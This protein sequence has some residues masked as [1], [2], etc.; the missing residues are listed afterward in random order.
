[1][2]RDYQISAIEEIRSHFDRKTKRVLLHLLTGAG[3]T[4]T[5]CEMLN[6]A[7]KKGTPSLLVVHMNQ[8]IRQAEERLIEDGIP[9]GVI[10]GNRT[11]DEFELIRVCS[12]QTL[13]RRKLI[14]PAKFIVIDE[15]H[16]TD[17]DQYKWLLDQYPD[18]Y[19]L[20]VT[21]TPHLKN[22]MRHV[23]DVVVKTITP[24]GL[25]NRGFV[26]PARYFATA[27]K[28]DLSDVKIVR[29]DYHQ[30]QLGEKMSALVGDVVENYR[31]FADGLPALAFA[32]NVKHS[33][34]IAETFNR[35][36]IS[37][38]H[39][40]A[41]TPYDERMQ[42]VKKLTDGEIKII[43][44][45]GTL[46]TGFDC[47][48]ARAI[49]VCRPTQSY[50]LHIQILGRGS[51]PYPGKENFIVIDHAGNTL[52]HGFY[53]TDRDCNLDGDGKKK[54]GSAESFLTE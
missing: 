21:A 10:Q 23:A 22:G 31:K 42:L 1:M 9:H 30:N 29:G 12:I 48:P 7:H 34:S 11:R 27:N 35:A 38:A 18:A 24:Q 39:V 13:Y 49:I 16:V 54:K 33:K 46:T 41:D 2:L 36:G 37:C 4:K 8:L 28:V 40:D 44:S 3:K 5:F 6:R 32:V 52:R 47:P 51:R 43:S 45:V 15:A 20:G 53:E 26:V 14:L 19:V 50:N 17:N 25:I